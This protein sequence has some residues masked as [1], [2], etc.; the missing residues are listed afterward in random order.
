M[1]E[2]DHKQLVCLNIVATLTNNHE[3]IGLSYQMLNE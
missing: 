1:F 2:I 3:Q